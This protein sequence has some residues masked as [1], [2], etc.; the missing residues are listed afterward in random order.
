MSLDPRFYG[1]TILSVQKNFGHKIEK[2]DL[3]IECG[4][5][6]SYLFLFIIKVLLTNKKTKFRFTMTDRVS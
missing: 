5:T 6:Q 2:F 3:G 1:P 4:P